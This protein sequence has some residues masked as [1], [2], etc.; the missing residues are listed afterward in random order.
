[1]IP[2]EHQEQAALVSWFRRSFP[3]VR[4]LAIP[5]GGVRNKA[6][7]ARL[8]SEGVSAG[9]PDLFIPAWRLWIE[10]K[11]TKGGAT[12]PAQKGWIEY[13]RG[14][15]YSVEVCRGAAEAMDVIKKRAPQEVR[16]DHKG[17]AEKN[18]R[19]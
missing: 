13:L 8:K 10:M 4:I 11:R 3:G 12:S 7:A 19:V 6:T 9:V 15:G 18:G 2:T 16:G 14:V 17:R 5:N 1:M